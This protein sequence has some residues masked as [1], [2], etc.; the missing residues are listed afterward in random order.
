MGNGTDYTKINFE[1]YDIVV[2][3]DN[4]VLQRKDLR[5]R[6]DREMTYSM[7]MEVLESKFTGIHFILK[8][9]YWLR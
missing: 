2:P 9:D 3:I 7:M 4:L 5:T 8:D 1:K 6:W